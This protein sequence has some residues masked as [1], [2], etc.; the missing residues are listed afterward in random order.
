MSASARIILRKKANSE[1]LYL[2]AIR[3]IKD[4]KATYYYIGQ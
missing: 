1:G 4:R 2:L 3:V